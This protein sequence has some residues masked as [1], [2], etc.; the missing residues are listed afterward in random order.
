MRLAIAVAGKGGTGKT[1]VAALIIGYLKNKFNGSILAVDADPTAN[2]EEA[3]GLEIKATIGATLA[4]FREE[5][6]NLPQGIPKNEYLESKLDEILVEGEKVDLLVMGCKE[7]SGCYCYPNQ[8]LRQYLDMLAKNYS[9]LIIDNE[10]GME[11]LSRRMTRELDF[12]FLVS[13]PTVRGIRT[14]GALRD[15]AKE[16][17][18]NIK[19]IFLIID[20][21][22]GELHPLVLEEIKK[23][24]LELIKTIPEDAMI[25]DYSLSGKPLTGLPETSVATR[26]INE[27][28]KQII[29]V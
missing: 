14:A 18:L 9:F 23:Q 6:S 5:L 20:K 24:R 1:T 22:H 25:V 28:M 12:L 10:A 8:I 19:E 4:K 7:G 21:L 3:I 15:L 29:A 27:L 13:D 26:A 16:L 2:L 17:E 11:H